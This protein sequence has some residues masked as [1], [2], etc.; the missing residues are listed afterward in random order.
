MSI[1]G[2]QVKFS[3]WSGMGAELDVAKRIEALVANVTQLRKE[4]AESNSAHTAA[5]AALRTDL[6]ARVSA[7]DL[8]VADVRAGSKNRRRAVSTSRWP[9]SLQS[10]WERF[11][12][13]LL[14]TFAPY[15]D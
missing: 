8:A 12:R 14:P 15:S 11:S 2:G 1:T 5:I 13:V 4:A 3:L 10:W 7:S 6:A 9:H